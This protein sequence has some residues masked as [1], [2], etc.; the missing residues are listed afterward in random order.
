GE[1]LSPAQALRAYTYGSAYA[2]FAEQRVGLLAPGYLADLAVLSADPLQAEDLESVAVLATVVGGKTV[3]DA[4]GLAW[5]RGPGRSAPGQCG[6]ATG[7][8]HRAA[9]A[10]R[11]HRAV[12]KPGFSRHRYSPDRRCCRHQLLHAVPLHG[13]QGRPA[14]RDSPGQLPPAD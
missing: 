7:R 3:H 6:A 5:R 1:R 2:A 10:P 13:H 14:L 4:A 12:R 9:G 11:R 8:H